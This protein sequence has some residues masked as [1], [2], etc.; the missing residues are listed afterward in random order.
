MYENTK[1]QIANLE[2]KAADIVAMVEDERRAMLPSE[3]EL[4]DELL[5]TAG[6]LKK[7]LPEPALTLQN[8]STGVGLPTRGGYALRGPIEAKAYKD[9]YGGDGYRW[10]DRDT[11]FFQAVF[12]GRHHPGLTIRAMN[13]T[14]PSDGGFLVPQ[15]TAA[16]IHNVSLENEVVMPRCFVQPMKSNTIKIPAMAIGSH[17]S[18]LLGGFTASYV[19]EAGTITEKDPKVRA[20]ELEAKKLTGLIRFTSELTADVPGGEAQ[21]INICGKGLAWYRDRAFLKGTGSGEPLGILNSP[22]VVEVKKEPGQ[23]AGTIVCENIVKMMGRMFPGSFKNSVWVAHQSTI[24]QLLTLSLGIGTGGSAIPVMS[25]TDGKFTMLT[26]PV[27]FTEKTETLGERGDIL[28]ADFSQYVVGLR[29]EMRFD[30][31]IHVHFETD[32][33]LARLIERHDGQPLW[34]EPLTLA[35]GSTTVSPFVVLEKR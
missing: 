32:E 24:P 16:Q 19:A 17:A 27:V 25:E 9:L 29:S 7:Q 35:D 4:H 14:V 26:R 3:K 20:M 2:R 10:P 21:I 28:L 5:A 18:A 15:E 8:F 23:K 22:C 13:E 12:S 30:T 34:D 31:S 33:L 1:T 11:S 6:E